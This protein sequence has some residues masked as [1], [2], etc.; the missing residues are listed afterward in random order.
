MSTIE[1]PAPAARDADHFV[2]T[3]PFDPASATHA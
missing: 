3:D 2:S 1:L